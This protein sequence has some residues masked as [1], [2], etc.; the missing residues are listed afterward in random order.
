MAA[1]PLQADPVN[2]SLTGEIGVLLDRRLAGV[3]FGRVL[4][5]GRWDLGVEVPGRLTLGFCWEPSSL[6][7]GL[8]RWAWPK[9]NPP[10]ALKSHLQSA[11]VEA[12]RALKG[13]P[14]LLF[15]LRGER[16]R[17]LVWEGIGRSSNLLL[18]DAEEMILWSGRV[19]GGPRRS[20]QPGTKW[21]APVA[22]TSPNFA[23]QTEH[24]A[25]AEHILFEVGPER[26][27]AN[28]VER[29]RKAGL[30]ALSAREKALLRRRE[31]VLGDR[32]Q[33]ETWLGGEELG[34]ALMAS[35]DLRKRGES[36]R[37]VTDYRRD[38]PEPV[39]VA[40][41]PSFTVLENAQLFFKKAKKGQ[42]RLE[43]TVAVLEGIGAQIA[44]V[45]AERSKIECSEDL[46][47]L[48]PAP[49]GQRPPSGSPAESRLP[50][51]VA[52]VPLPMGFFGYAGKNAHGNDAVSFKIGKGAD[53]WF[54]AEDYAGCHVVVRNPDRRE[55]LPFQVEQAAG[56]YA[57]AHSAAPR[58]NRVAVT[59]ARCKNLR[60][61]PGAPGKVWVS[62]PRTLFVDLPSSK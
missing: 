17:T 36:V 18:L 20:G 27:R 47:R 58:G 2:P 37:R 5:P 7:V 41:N 61:V 28:L 6:A 44:L 38:P 16:A 30:A 13:E 52:R 3:F 9:G 46:N 54:H 57:A 31:A 23:F 29:G 53:Y 32:V 39:E 51:G 10:E 62:G 45:S 43:R 25:G 56:L 14:V 55:D 33:A 12:V 21:A 4:A 49:K 15:D 42:A 40:L 11:R 59:V 24:P 8:C 22:R 34:Q 1:P 50:P 19:L 48:Y 26:I 35:G 60:R